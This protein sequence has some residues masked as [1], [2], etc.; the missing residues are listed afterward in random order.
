M[1]SGLSGLAAD[2]IDSIVAHHRLQ[3]LYP[4]PTVQAVPARLDS[5][6]LRCV[7]EMHPNLILK[8]RDKICLLLQSSPCCACH[9]RPPTA[10][11]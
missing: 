6:D 8:S 5:I 4:P 2:K 11:L 7:S 10:L 1:N 9:A 3:A